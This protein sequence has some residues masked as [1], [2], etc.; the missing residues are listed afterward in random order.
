MHYPKEI[1][2]LIF[3]HFRN[4]T[5]EEVGELILENVLD[6]GYL[7]INEYRDLLCRVVV[8]DDDFLKSV[9]S[10]SDADGDGLLSFEELSS[11]EAF[12]FELI[13]Y[14]DRKKKSIS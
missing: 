9:I 7:D 14:E 6:D 8:I 4:S 13:H 12:Q 1:G 10:E 2:P 5:S 11:A 3:F